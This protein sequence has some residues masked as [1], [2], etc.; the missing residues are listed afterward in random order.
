MGDTSSS[1]VAQAR[2]VAEVL[3]A[4][5]DALRAENA[6]LREALEYI[7]EWES[8]CSNR[9]HGDTCLEQGALYT[10][11]CVACAARR[12]LEEG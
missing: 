9:R 7:R 12:A 2:A 4:E 3:K 1:G 8:E 6:R 10:A 5:R 11:P